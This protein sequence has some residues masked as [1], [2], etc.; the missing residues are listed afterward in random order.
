MWLSGCLLARV[1][2]LLDSVVKVSLGGSLQP[3]DSAMI[4]VTDGKDVQNSKMHLNP[5]NDLS[6]TLTK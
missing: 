4:I 1:A 3:Q 2:A 6:L 5:C